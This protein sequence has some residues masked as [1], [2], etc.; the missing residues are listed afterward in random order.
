L[1]LAQRR[2]LAPERIDMGVLADELGVNRV[3]LYR[4]FDSRNDFLVKVV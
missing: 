4:W 3:T 1:R 2:F